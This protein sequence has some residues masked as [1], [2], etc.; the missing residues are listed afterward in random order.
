M[1]RSRRVRRTTRVAFEVAVE[2]L[3]FFIN[4][5][6]TRSGNH[7]GIVVRNYDGGSP[8][9]KSEAHRVIRRARSRKCGLRIVIDDALRS[10]RAS[11][12]SCF[13]VK[14]GMKI[15]ELPSLLFHRTV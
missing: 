3:T 5:R 2:T 7:G 4:F 14:R 9:V 15:D 10:S 8:S 1:D 12:H 11:L 13:S 6:M